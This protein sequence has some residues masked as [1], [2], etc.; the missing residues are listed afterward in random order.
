MS[1]SLDFLICEMGLMRIELNWVCKVPPWAQQ[2]FSIEACLNL[3]FLQNLSIFQSG[4]L[5]A[6][7]GASE[8]MVLPMCWLCPVAFLLASLP[9]IRL[10]GRCFSC[11]LLCWEVL[12]HSLIIT[13]PNWA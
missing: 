7:A 12:S 11:S 10:K 13:G 1:L 4:L 5:P 3:L 6:Q 9:A 8:T 2:V